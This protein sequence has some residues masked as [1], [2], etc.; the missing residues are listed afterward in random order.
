L[1][2]EHLFPC[3]RLR[4]NLATGPPSGPPL[5]LLHGV[6]RRWQSFLPLVP[7]LAPRWQLV[8]P[9]LRG[10]GGSDRADAYRVRDHLD[11]VLALLR[12]RASE[13]VVIYGHS[14][15][16]LLAAGAAAREPNRVRAIILEDPPSQALLQALSK[17]MYNSLFAGMRA[18]AGPGR[19]VRALTREL[20]GLR[21]A[22]PGQEGVR[23]GDLRDATSLRFTARCLQNMDPAALTPLLEGGWLHGLDLPAIYR[24]VRCPALLL[25]A[26][27][28]FGGM[29]ARPDADAAAGLM[30]ECH[31]I[32]FPRV[33]H[34]I[35]WLAPQEC[36]RYVLGFLESLE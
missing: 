10:H 7:A 33:G 28:P 17:T 27:V 36:L 34:Q 4:L 30:A 9:D 24:G 14:L 20:A 19:P 1:F 23:L 25:R 3:G 8:A 13:P 22:A 32:D 16:A 15:G 18:L 31:V 2:S 26:D 5:L 6:S 29:M 35:H 21:I 11:D 12:E